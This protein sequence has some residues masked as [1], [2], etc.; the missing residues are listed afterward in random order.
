MVYSGSSVSG[1][2]NIIY[3]NISA[4]NA[5]YAGNASL[6]YTCSTPAPAGTGN[7]GFDPLFVNPAAGNFNLMSNS[8]CIDTGNPSLPLDP[9]GTQADMGYMFFD[10]NFS[11]NLATNLTPVGMPIVIPANG[12]TIEFN[13]E[14]QNLESY[15]VGFSVWTNVTLPSGGVTAPLINAAVTLP[16]NITADRDRT[17]DI[18]AVAPAGD[19]VYNSYVGLYP[20]L[21]LGEDHFNFSKS[22]DDNWGPYIHDWSNTGES[23]GEIEIAA[24]T[25]IVSSYTMISAFPNPFNPETTIAF[26][27]AQDVRVNLAVFDIQGREIALLEDGFMN[28]GNHQRGFKA[29]NLPSGV[30]FARLSAGGEIHTQKLLLVK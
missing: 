24:D 7:I 20:T 5:N 9:D 14:V 16:G 10:Q 19:Y 1:T 11:A 6:T 21:I 27:L 17:Q 12:G 13:I 22:A 23:F 4:N 26:T 8:P 3:G 18:P 2:N 28:A 30:Y 25:K 15:P 29:E